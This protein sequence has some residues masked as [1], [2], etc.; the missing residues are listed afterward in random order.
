[1]HCLQQLPTK[2]QRLH[3]LPERTEGLSEQ[4]DAA[5]AMQLSH[6]VALTH[7]SLQGNFVEFTQ[8]DELPAAL[9]VLHLASCRCCVQPLLKLTQ[10]TQLCVSASRTSAVQLQQLADAL[11]ALQHVELGYKS[12]AAADAAARAWPLLPLRALDIHAHYGLA[13]ATFVAIVQLTN[14]TRLIIRSMPLNPHKVTPFLLAGHVR[15]LTALQELHIVRFDFQKQQQASEQDLQEQQQRQQLYQQLNVHLRQLHLQRQQQQQQQGSQESD[16]HATQ[17][18]Q[19]Q[20]QQYLAGDAA[21]ATASSLATAGA[22]VSGIPDAAGPLY[23]AAA[24]VIRPDMLELVHAIASLR[25]L[26]SLELK[27]IRLGNA[28]AQLAAATQLTHVR[29]EDCGVLDPVAR[30]V[31]HALNTVG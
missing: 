6:L 7:L 31:V 26:R 18:E 30:R 1:M 24:L 8:Q 27:R 14:L 10:L 22:A 9:K 16:E 21:T 2:L 29:L 5:Q 3:L 11:P 20:G 19:Q 4:D 17:E 28:A 25:N 15:Q 13:V 12:A 23:D